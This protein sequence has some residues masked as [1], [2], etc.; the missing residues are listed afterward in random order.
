MVR[1][2]YYETATMRKTGKMKDGQIKG[3]FLVNIVP[4]EVPEVPPIDENLKGQ[5]K[6]DALARREKK[7][8]KREAD[9]AQSILDCKFKACDMVR[10]LTGQEGVLVATNQIENKDL[11]DIM[12]W[13][14]EHEA[15]YA[16]FKKKFPAIAKRFEEV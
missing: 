13:I 8:K 16:D 3:T 14:M 5:E 4:E 1:V 7:L 6:K 11:I 10:E 2:D 15:V 12:S 9:I